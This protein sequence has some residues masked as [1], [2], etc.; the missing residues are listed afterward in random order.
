M[1]DTIFAFHVVGMFMREERKLFFIWKQPDTERLI[2]L[3]FEWLAPFRARDNGPQ[4]SAH[5]CMSAHDQAKT[6]TYMK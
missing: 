6:L 1:S 4:K 3:A 2:A 5:L